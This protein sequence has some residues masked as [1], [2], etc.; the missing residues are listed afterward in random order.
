MEGIS[1]LVNATAYSIYLGARN[2]SVTVMNETRATDYA[3]VQRRLVTHLAELFHPI[4][5]YTLF[6]TLLLVFKIQS[7]ELE[8]THSTQQCTSGV[9]VARQS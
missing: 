7:V 2:L 6:I 9:E 1:R 4:L 5:S 8:H 3:L